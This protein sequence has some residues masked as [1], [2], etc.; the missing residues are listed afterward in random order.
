MPPL[1][2]YRHPATV[3]S[4]CSVARSGLA[5]RA[6]QR[7]ARPVSLLNRR[8]SPLTAPCASTTRGYGF[9]RQAVPMSPPM[10]CSARPLGCSNGVPRP[11][12]AD[13]PDHAL[14]PY[15]SH[16][17]R[18]PRVLGAALVGAGCVLRPRPA[19]LGVSSEPGRQVR[20][21]EIHAIAS[22]EPPL[23]NLEPVPKICPKSIA[24]AA[25]EAP[26]RQ[27]Q[28]SRLVHSW[29]AAYA[30]QGRQHCCRT[31]SERGSAG[32]PKALSAR[33]SPA[34]PCGNASGS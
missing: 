20:R 27:N 3:G 32:R 26:A 10:A 24:A 34:S 19:R 17:P 9:R 8:R 2:P 5:A 1:P 30:R 6:G 18:S 28:S 14:L 7:V 31:A 11:K 15:P 33:R 21:F 23:R 25:V 16:P 29:R 22:P 12:P 4:S 13:R